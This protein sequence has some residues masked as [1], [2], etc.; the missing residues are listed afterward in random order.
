MTVLEYFARVYDQLIGVTLPSNKSANEKD[1]R[2]PL[3]LAGH[4]GSGKSLML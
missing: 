1:V 3:V 2:E 4:S